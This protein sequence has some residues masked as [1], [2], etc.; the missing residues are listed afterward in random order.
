MARL[1]EQDGAGGSPFNGVRLV[2]SPNAVPGPTI[3]TM[4]V[5]ANALCSLTE[6]SVGAGELSGCSTALAT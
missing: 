4:T 6:S 2:P 5:S 1:H 3:A